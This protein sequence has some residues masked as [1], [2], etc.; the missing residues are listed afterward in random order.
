MRFRVIT[1]PANQ[2]GHGLVFTDEAA[3]TQVTFYPTARPDSV[4]DR[5]A[6]VDVD[7]TPDSVRVLATVFPKADG[8]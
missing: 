2:E 5:D 7:L 8:R 6:L 3:G 4:R 1:D